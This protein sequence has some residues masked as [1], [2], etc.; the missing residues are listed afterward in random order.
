MNIGIVQNVSLEGIQLYDLPDNFTAGIGE[1]FKIKV[2]GFP[3]AAEYI[4]TVQSKWRCK[5]GPHFAVGFEIV[6]APAEW[7]LLIWQVLPPKNAVSSKKKTL[8]YQQQ[9][10]CA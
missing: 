5:N 3:D 9:P 7:N 4:L 6:Q 1:Q 2:S 8:Q 10:A